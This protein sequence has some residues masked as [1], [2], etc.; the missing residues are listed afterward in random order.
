MNDRMESEKMKMRTRVLLSLG[1][2][3]L[4]LVAAIGL[5][6][7]LPTSV[8]FAQGSSLPIETCT[9]VATTRTCEFWARPDTVT[10]PDGQVVDVWRI[11]ATPAGPVPPSDSLIVANAGETL[12]VILHND[13]P[14]EDVSLTF[15]G[16]MGVAPDL[17]GIP[18]GGTT[19]YSFVLNQP[20]TFVFEAGMTPNGLRQ[21]AM[22]LYGALVVRP[23]AAPNQ[24][25]DDPATAF[26]VEDLVVLGAI[27]SAFNADPNNFSMQFYEPEYWLINGLAYSD[28]IPIDTTPGN[29]LLLRYINATHETQGMGILGLRQEVIGFDGRPLGY[30]YGVVNETIASG[31]TLDTL[32]TIPLGTPVDTL[33]PLY[34]TSFLLHNSSDRMGGNGPL[35]YGGMMTFIR[36]ITGAPGTLDGP[37]ASN[38]TVEPSPTNGSVPVTLTVTLDDSLSGAGTVVAAEYFTDTLGAPGTGIPIPVDVPA[39]TVEVSTTIPTTALGTWPS[40]PI[41]FFVRGQNANLDWGAPGSAV[42]NL[43]TLGPDI[44]GLSLSVNPTNGTRDILLRATGDDRSNGNQNVVAGEFQ[45]DGGAGLPMFLARIDAPVVAMT[46]IISTTLQSTLVEGLHAVD[47]TAQDSLGNW[48]APGTIRSCRG[49][50]RTAGDRTDPDAEYARPFGSAAG[51]PC[52]AGGQHH[53]YPVSRRPVAAGQC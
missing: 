49:P 33:F 6:L 20:G 11:A 34:N 40:G 31:Q 50:H 25:Y 15:P 23:A 19:T 53:R 9:L 3:L 30:P 4:A 28:T 24:A 12:E 52:T 13:L 47:V 44:S 39:L 45:I 7:L 37:S 46:A 35:H 18:L 32:V 48:G 36:T 43:D 26:D 22:G 14:G 41:T 21:V 17:V 10:L 16:Q 38:V 27:D 51:D 42:L 2:L 29:N 5:A 1:C 8:A